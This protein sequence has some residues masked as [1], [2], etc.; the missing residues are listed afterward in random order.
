MPIPSKKDSEYKHHD[1]ALDKERE[2]R[3]FTGLSVPKK[4]EANL[5]FKQK[6]RVQVLNDPQAIDKRRQ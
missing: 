5:P 6:Q 4:I 2:E 1:E 3:V